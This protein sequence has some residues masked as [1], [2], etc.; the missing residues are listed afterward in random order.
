M[1]AS[2]QEGHDRIFIA[3][4]QAWY[5]RNDKILMLWEVDLF[6]QYGTDDPPTDFLLSTLWQCFEEGLLKIFSDCT[7]IVTPGGE[8]QY[9][10]AL[11]PFSTVFEKS[12]GKHIG[13]SGVGFGP[14][15]SQGLRVRRLFQPGRQSKP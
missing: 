4:L 2:E 11:W 5:Y 13:G 10:N 1:L 8:P 3:G 7:Q 12:Y 9:D 14:L 15:I 6:Q